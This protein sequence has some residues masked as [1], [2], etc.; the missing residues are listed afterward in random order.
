MVINRSIDIE[1]AVRAV[2][3]EYMTAYCR[4]LPAEYSLPN[5]LVTTT[6]GDTDSAASG[7]GKVDHFMVVL[8]ARAE[9]EAEAMELIRTAVAVLESEMLFTEVNSLYSWGADPVR[10]DL[11]MCSA[12][13]MVTAHREIVTL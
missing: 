7:K 1:D 12:T 8:D 4:P 5:V 10:P 6:G 3:S 2:L 9:T 13:L 11:A